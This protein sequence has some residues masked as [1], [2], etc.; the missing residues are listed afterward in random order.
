MLTQIPSVC[1]LVLRRNCG[2]AMGSL[3]TSRCDPAKFRRTAGRGRPGT[4]GDR[5]SGPR[6]PVPGLGCGGGGAGEVGRRRPGAV[7]AAA[8]CAGEVGRRDEK[9]Q[10]GELGEVQGTVGEGLFGPGAGR[11]QSSPRQ[12]LMAPA[13]A[14]SWPGRHAG[15]TRG[16]ARSSI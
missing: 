2:F 7:A 6:G 12:P 8:C 13:P 10:A 5:P 11:N 3:S 14:R 16:A 9:R 4:C 1:D 15:R